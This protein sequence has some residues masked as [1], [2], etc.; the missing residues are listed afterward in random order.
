[1]EYKG[2]LTICTTAKHLVTLHKIF[3]LHIKTE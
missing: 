3:N 2:E 1:M